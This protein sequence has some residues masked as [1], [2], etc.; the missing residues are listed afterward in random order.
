VKHL[1]LAERKGLGTLR[2]EEIEVVGEPIE[3]V[4]RK[5]RRS[6]ISKLLSW[7]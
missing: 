3:R 2:I 5:F 7:F 4:A 1:V 6:L